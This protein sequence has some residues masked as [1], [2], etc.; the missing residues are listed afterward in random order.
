M[1]MFEKRAARTLAGDVQA[2][3][4][5]LSDESRWTHGTRA[6]LSGGGTHSNGVHPDAVKWC[7]VGAIDHEV[8]RKRQDRVEAFLASLFSEDETR[9]A[10]STFRPRDAQ[11]KLWTLNDMRG[12]QRVTQLLD[13]AAV[14]ALNAA[15]L[16]PDLPLAPPEPA[17]KSA[18][19]VASSPRVSMKEHTQ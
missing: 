1:K 6:V 4:V 12:Y 15:D 5:L 18:P 14:V 2:V 19:V 8:P 3:R 17:L 9:V 10:W 7:L 11:S 13:E 16:L